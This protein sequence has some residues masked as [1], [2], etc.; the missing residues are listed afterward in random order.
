MISCT[1]FIPAYSELFRFLDELEGAPGEEPGPAVVRF[2]ESLSDAFL[3]N[4]RDLAVEKGL[5]GCFEYWSHTLTEE[6]ADF[7]MTLDEE[8]GAFEIEMRRCPSKGRLLASPHLE[9][10]AGYCRHCDTLYRR[11]LEPLGYRYEIDLSRSNEAR[12]TLRVWGK[13]LTLK[14]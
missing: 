2:W 5:A 8:G 12:C 4:L 6:A 3:G 10:Y 1:E 9:P 13:D 14:T 7:L 11:V